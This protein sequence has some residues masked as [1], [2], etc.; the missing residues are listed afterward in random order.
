[1]ADYKK[2][3]IVDTMTNEEILTLL[4]SD[5]QF[6]QHK[7]DENLKTYKRLIKN[8]A[9]KNR[10]YYNPLNYKSA[11]GFNWVIQ[12]FKRGVD[13]VDEKSKLGTL[14]Y[15]WFVKNRGIYAVTCSRLSLYGKYTWH[16]TIYTPHFIDR[17]KERFLK[18][19]SISKPDAFYKYFRNNLKLTSSGHPSQ[20]YPNGFWLVCND[21]MCLCNHLN[22][23]TVEVKTFITYEMAHVEEKEFVQ[24]AKQAMLDRGFELRLPEEDFDEYV[25]EDILRQEVT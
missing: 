23:L 12:F 3:V 17:Y 15:T 9:S 21:G 18:D 13:E 2:S 1:M 8:S 5:S 6:L 24:K 20:K 4:A 7:I 11:K 19:K 10:I 25:K 16:F 14:Y 22:S